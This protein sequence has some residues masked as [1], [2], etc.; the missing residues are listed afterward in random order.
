MTRCECRTRSAVGTWAVKVGRLSNSNTCAAF[1]SAKRAVAVSHRVDTVG[2]SSIFAVAKRAVVVIIPVIAI[3]ERAV[4][5]VA[6]AIV[7]VLRSN[8]GR[9]VAKA[10]TV[11]TSIVAAVESVAHTKVVLGVFGSKVASVIP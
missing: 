8:A 3:A 7:V 10:L 9:T 2:Y 1:A 6:K 5:A 11:A 4:V